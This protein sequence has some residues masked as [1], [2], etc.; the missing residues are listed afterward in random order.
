[1]EGLSSRRPIVRTRSPEKEVAV[2]EERTLL[3]D[4]TDPRPGGD[5]VR[6]RLGSR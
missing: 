1:M 6:V 3:G 5:T 2:L 4:L